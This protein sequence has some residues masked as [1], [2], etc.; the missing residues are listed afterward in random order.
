MKIIEALSKKLE[1]LFEEHFAS[2][3]FDNIS[4]SPR[5]SPSVLHRF[6]PTE[7]KQI[8]GRYS[9]SKKSP[10]SSATENV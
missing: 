3:D 6:K 9:H 5:E 2:W 7:L 1:E 10:S 8:T 4:G